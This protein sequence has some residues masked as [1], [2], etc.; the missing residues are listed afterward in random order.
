M[1]DTLAERFW[2]KVTT[3]TEGCWDWNGA[4][5]QGYGLLGRSGRGNGNIRAHRLSWE[6]HYGP[7]P[8]GMFVL[9]KCDNPPCAKPEHLFL[10]DQA[11]NMHDASVK[12]R[13]NTPSH[14]GAKNPK[15]RLTRSDVDIIRELYFIDNFS[16]EAIAQ[17][18]GIGQV[19]VS[20][21]V[22][23]NHWTLR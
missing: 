4:T 16:Q 18:F 21:I 20:R 2:K 1:R 14:H 3:S 9:H 15:A 12:G 23:G 5:V 22:N 10:G 11:A 8:D 7:I 17:R 13:M 6:L 19:T